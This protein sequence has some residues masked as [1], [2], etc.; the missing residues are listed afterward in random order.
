MPPSLYFEV[1]GQD[2][3]RL[4]SACQARNIEPAKAFELFLEEFTKTFSNKEDEDLRAQKLAYAG[5]LAKYANPALISL[6]EQ[7]VEMAIKEKYGLD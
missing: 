7:A 5:C 4:L 6:E 1:T 3:Q 2:A